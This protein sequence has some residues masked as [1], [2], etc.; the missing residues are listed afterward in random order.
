MGY[1][2]ATRKVLAVHPGAVVPSFLDDTTIFGRVSKGVTSSQGVI[3]DPVLPTLKRE[4]AAINLEFNWTKTYFYFGGRSR[5]AGFNCGEASVAEAGVVSLGVLIGTAAYVVANVADRLS[6]SMR[7]LE[8]VAQ[9]GDFHCSMLMLR[10]SLVPRPRFLASA[11]PANLLMESFAKWDCTLQ[12]SLRRLLRSDFLHPRCFYNRAVG[13][14]LSM[15][16]DE[17]AIY[18]VNGWDRCMRVIRST[19]PLLGCGFWRRSRSF[20]FPPR[21]RSTGR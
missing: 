1:M 9:V 14:G 8:L 16:S 10:K 20:L 13:L 17:H 12:A 4:A 3:S 2:V 6:T 11:L 15:M 21:T 7:Q 18:R 19:W 5:P